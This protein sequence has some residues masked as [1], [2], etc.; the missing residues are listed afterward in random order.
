LPREAASF[1][2][3]TGFALRSEHDNG[4]VGQYWFL[5]AGKL[6]LFATYFCEKQHVGQETRAVMKA[7]TSLGFR[8]SA[9]RRSAQPAQ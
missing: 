1:G 3:F 6:L 7:L 4:Q 2:P 5:R 8:L 9:L